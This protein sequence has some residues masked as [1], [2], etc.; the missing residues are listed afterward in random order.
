MATKTYSQPVTEALKLK[1]S[2]K[3]CEGTFPGED[4][5]DEW[6]PSGSTELKD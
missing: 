6:P 1:L 3:I 4:G 2:G 5:V